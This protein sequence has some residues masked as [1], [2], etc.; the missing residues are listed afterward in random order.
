MSR[1]LSPDQMARWILGQSSHEEQ[2]HGQNCASCSAQLIQFQETVSTFQMAMKNWSK[3]ET[4]PKLEKTPN[5][6]VAWRRLQ[7][8][9]FRWALVGIAIVVLAVIPIYKLPQ[10]ESERGPV[11]QT[12]SKARIREDVRLMEEVT[13]R[14]SH[15]LPKP[16]QRV[17][18]L[19]PSEEASMLE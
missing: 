13:T 11:I 10:P 19:L 7:H 5:N 15:P 16:M 18:V 14:L 17:I 9:S 8:P 1:H 12:E 6:S 4:V 2:E 3:L